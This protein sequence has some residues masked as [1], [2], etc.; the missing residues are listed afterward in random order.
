[1]FYTQ[2]F[3]SKILPFMRYCGKNCRVGQATDGN[4][5]RRM[6]IACW[7][8]KAAYRLSGYIIPI[9]LPL[10]QWLRERTSVLRYTYI[11]CLAHWHGASN[12]NMKRSERRSGVEFLFLLR[13]SSMGFRSYIGFWHVH[14]EKLQK[15]AYDCG[16]VRLSVR[17]Y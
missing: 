17:K 13:L 12:S 8:T 6:R 5:I 4:I 14:G 11:A 1:M 3:F 2:Y 10:Q 15:P 9:A 7:I 16:H